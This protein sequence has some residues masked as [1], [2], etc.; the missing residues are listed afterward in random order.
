MSEPVDWQKYER[1]QA[2]AARRREQ[3]E[4]L[5]EVERLERLA[6]LHPARMRALG[7]ASEA[8][9]KLVERLTLREAMTPQ[10]VAKLMEAK[11]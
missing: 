5:P 10:R 7:A 9:T 1:L 8:N 11:G 6:D 2:E 4:T 3:R